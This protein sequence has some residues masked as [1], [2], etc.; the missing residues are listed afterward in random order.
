MSSPKPAGLFPVP[1]MV[2]K[3]EFGSQEYG[4]LLVY[5][6]EHVEM[7]KAKNRGIRDNLLPKWVRIYKGVPAEKERS[8]PWPGASNLIVQLAATHS[9]ELLSRVMAIYANDPLF[10]AKAYGDFEQ[11]A[12]DDERKAL[13]DF[14]GIVSLEPD[15]LDL[16]RVEES[17]FSSSIRYG[18][19]IVKFPWEYI[20]EKQEIYIG[21]GTT[22]GSTAT[23][24]TEEMT[25]RDGPHPENVPLNCFGIDTNAANMANASFIYHTIPMNK[26]QLRDLKY[27]PEIV[28]TTAV[29]MLLAL[30]PDREGPASF[31]RELAASK[32][33]DAVTNQLAGEWDI[34]ECWFTFN[35][36]GQIFNF[37]ARYHYGSKTTMGI[38]YNPYPRNMRVFEDAKL[39]Y[40]DDT[41]HGFGFCEMLESYQREIS[42]THNWRVDNRHFATTGIGRVNKNSK[43]SSILQLY[44]GVL[45]PA[46]KD[47][48]DFFPINQ[49]AGLMTTEDEVLTLGLAKER[50]GVDPAIG[51]SGGG[52]VNSKKGNFSTQGMTVMQWQNNRN[53]LRMS[54]MR[55]AHVRMGRKLTEI[56]AHFGIGNKLRSYGD[57]AELLAK[58]LQHYKD[59]KLGLLIR[60]ATASYNREVEK[61]NDILLSQTLERLYAGD[62]QILQ[63]LATPGLP[64]EMKAY[65]VE[66][67]KAKNGLMKTILRNF[68]HDDV[69]RLIPV[70]A[71]MKEQRNAIANGNNPQA[72]Q[73]LQ[74]TNGAVPVS[75]GSAAGAVPQ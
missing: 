67:L 20:T 73:Q 56:Y 74:L 49:G 47:E 10:V 59:G 6:D 30:G 16:Y 13:E 17:W 54:D 3:E 52:S 39:A 19:G 15:E 21:G 27:H 60:P 57:K 46:D 66:V 61:Q 4:E 62:A 1:R 42:T 58:A 32:E 37:V 64:D 7:L 51:G 22:N 38:I 75:D 50:S 12:G 8:F 48:V 18:T 53:N 40:D 72:A 33:G 63:A 9:D 25:R 11:G 14:L 65:Y 69:D 23:Y 34:D 71:F 36:G 43:L 45:I 55:S 31:Q 44:P 24:R 70:P 28:S 2:T 41:Y 26:I 29:D 5:I 35:K 68:Q